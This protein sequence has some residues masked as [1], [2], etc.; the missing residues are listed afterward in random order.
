[1]ETNNIRNT[2]ISKIFIFFG[3]IIFIISAIDLAD[4]VFPLGLA[5]SEWVFGV[6]QT[7]IASILAPALSLII[8]LTGLYFANNSSVSKKLLHFEKLVGI[9]SFIFG[10]ALIANLLVYSLSMKA[11]ET[12]MIS[13]IKT[14]Q[15]EILNKISQLKNTPKLNIS[16]DVYNKKVAEINNAVAQQIKIAKKDLLKKNIKAIIELLLYIGLYLGIGKIAF[17]FSRMNLLKLKF[18]NK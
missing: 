1:M 6:T 9:I 2:E 15:E 14:Q 18:A 10:L 3:I 12:K 16:E 5:S 11:Y 17:V 13:S 7:V 4:T 8:L